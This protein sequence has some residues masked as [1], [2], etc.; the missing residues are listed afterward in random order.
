[1]AGVNYA[2]KELTGEI[3]HSF[4]E[5]LEDHRQ[6]LQERFCNYCKTSLTPIYIFFPVLNSSVLC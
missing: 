6:L 5:F 4:G 2:V 1:M 3:P